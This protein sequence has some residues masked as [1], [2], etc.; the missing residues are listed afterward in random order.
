MLFIS[1]GIIVSVQP[2]RDSEFNNIVDILSFAKDCA[3]AATA[4][5]LEG[6]NSILFGAKNIALPI[7][8]LIK[9]PFEKRITPSFTLAKK[10]YDAGASY[11]AMECT[12]RVRLKDIE[13][14]VEAGIQVIADV[15]DY[16]MAIEAEKI[17]CVAVTT[18]LSGYVGFKAHPFDEPHFSTLA[19]CCQHLKI[20]VIAEG[21]Y[22]TA[23]HVKKA[24]ELGAHSVCIGNAIHDP[25]YTV[26]YLKLHFNG[27]W[28]KHQAN[29]FTEIV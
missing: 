20:P 19:L 1:P 17:G 4:L 3:F 6:E 5:R 8:G 18:A 22:R 29:G 23:E 16:E 9:E 27:T 7:I 15:E 21:R 10:C 26:Q 11:V 2:R 25:Y 28:E 12:K 14:A 13:Q 24:K